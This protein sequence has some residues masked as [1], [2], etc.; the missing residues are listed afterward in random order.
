[1]SSTQKTMLAFC[2]LFALLYAFSS[3]EHRDSDWEKL[4]AALTKPNKDVDS[5]AAKS[6]GHSVDA[7]KVF[8]IK[9]YN[10]YFYEDG[11]MKTR[12]PAISEIIHSLQGNGMIFLL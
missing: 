7:G 11:Q 12:N 6:A 10:N 3:G 2:I 4:K 8:L 5:V 9:L 1:M